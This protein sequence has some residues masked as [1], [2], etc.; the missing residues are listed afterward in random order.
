MDLGSIESSA[1]THFTWKTFRYSVWCQPVDDRGPVTIASSS[2]HRSRPKSC[3]YFSWSKSCPYF[4]LAVHFTPAVIR[5]IARDHP[6]TPSCKFKGCVDAS[7]QAT[8]CWANG[9]LHYCLAGW[10]VC[11]LTALLTC[12]PTGIV[13]ARLTACVRA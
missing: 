3:P 9:L 13:S 8:C 4:F 6:T 12:W 10:L 7:R 2:A 5:A 1:T 11:W